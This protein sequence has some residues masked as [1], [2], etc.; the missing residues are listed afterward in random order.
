[1]WG[2]VK[3]PI[4]N[5][6]GWQ[7]A[8]KAISGFEAGLKMMV[9]TT[10][11]LG[12]ALGEQHDLF[13]APRLSG[14]SLFEDRVS[15]A[16]ERALI[17]AI[18][19][20]GLSPFRFQGWLGKRLTA[21]YGWSYDFDKGGLKPAPP[22]PHWL[23]PLRETVARLAGLSVD[24]L[25]QALLIRYDPGAGIGWHRDRPVFG[26]IVGV[27]LGAPAM[28]RFRRR[29]SGGFDRTSVYLPP[30]SIYHLTGDARHFWEHSI[31]PINE[32]RRSVTFRSLVSRSEST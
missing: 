20:V 32:P 31:A 2:V 22:L 21:A 8:N 13:A 27:S 4:A 19:G 17:D 1:L 18:D 23:L 15:E 16:E 24:E 25:A 7:N 30:R 9:R 5:H 29:R 6:R 28:M 14:L 26:E 11:P 3:R 10:K 12:P